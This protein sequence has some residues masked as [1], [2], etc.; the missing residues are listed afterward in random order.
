MAEEE[1]ALDDFTW[2][3]AGCKY[4]DVERIAH[5]AAINRLII[6]GGLINTDETS[7][8]RVASSPCMSSS[9]NL[10]EAVDAPQTLDDLR[11]QMEEDSVVNLQDSTP[12]PLFGR[13]RG[14]GPL[15]HITGHNNEIRDEESFIVESRRSS[16]DS[17]QPSLALSLRK[18]SELCRQRKTTSSSSLVESQAPS[19]VGSAVAKMRGAS[20][21]KP[22][23]RGGEAEAYFRD[24]AHGGLLQI[25]EQLERHKME[26]EDRGAPKEMSM[27]MSKL[28]NSF[29]SKWRTTTH[30]M[31]EDALDVHAVNDTNERLGFTLLHHQI[32]RLHIKV[33]ETREAAAAGLLTTEQVEEYPL[34][35]LTCVNPRGVKV[36]KT[37]AGIADMIESIQKDIIDPDEASRA[38]IGVTKCRLSVIGMVMQWALWVGS[39]VGVG[40]VSSVPQPL[41]CPTPP[42]KAMGSSHFQRLAIE[43][44]KDRDLLGFSVLSPTVQKPAPGFLTFDGGVS[45]RNQST[46]LTEGALEKYV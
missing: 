43:S 32:A 45:M 1:R 37:N 41:P 8:K 5:A 33:L 9:K 2:T 18:V 14:R 42:Q 10:R 25:M 4:T 44:L 46:K 6:S 36:I 24:A 7:L 39:S 29:K 34:Q 15:H 26:I 20:R 38:R 11:K 19:R 17:T 23:F 27:H 13:A 28:G 16:M 3:N 21:R 40:A 35:C 30:D 22:H 31:W 12:M